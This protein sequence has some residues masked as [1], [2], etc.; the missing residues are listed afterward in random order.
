MAKIDVKNL[1][2]KTVGDVDLD[3][4]VF[5]AEV[6]EHLL[7]EVV[8][9][10][11][12]EAPRRHR[13]RPSAAARS[14]AAA[15]SSWKQKGTGHARQGSRH[16]PALGRRRQ[17]RSGPSRATTSTTCRRRSMAGALRS[18]LSLR[19]KEQKIVVLDELHARRAKTKRVADGARRR[20]APATALIVD[21]KTTRSSRKST[22]NLAD[23]EVA[24]ARGAQRLRRARPR[25]ARP[26]AGRGSTRSTR[27]SAGRNGGRCS[28]TRR[29]AHH[30]ASA[31]HRE[32]HA[33]ARDRRRARR[34]LRRGRRLR[35]QVALRGRARREQDRD[36][37]RGRDAVQGQGRRRPHADRARQGEAR[38]PVRRSAARTGRRRS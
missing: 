30:Q 13:A 23:V 25:D 32:G 6:N 3:D 18:A 19:A 21:A 37:Q 36:Q 14:A 9:C 26:D 15:R 27:A 17:G 35:Q 33:P 38:R 5:G 7:W 8:K 24:R 11:A 1:D 4:A 28:M 20:S 31:P 22:R 10:A 12:R 16:A 34:H 2:G 29:A